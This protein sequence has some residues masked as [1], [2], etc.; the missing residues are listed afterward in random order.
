MSMTATADT[1]VDVVRSFFAAYNAHDV[2]RMVA[3][4]SA[5]A[6]LRYV[7]MGRQGQ[8]PIREIGKNF[9]SGLI[10]AFPDLAV[11]VESAFGD[12][13]NVAAEVMIGGTQRKDFLGIRN[14]GKHYDLP[15]AFLVK[16]NRESLITE[17]ACY[18]DNVTFYSQLGKNTIP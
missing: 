9:W 14:Q 5:D 1:A 10:D 6:Q 4:C 2:N 11:E 7:P 16:L 18:W 3:A 15:H 13:R 8:G 17:V 12:E